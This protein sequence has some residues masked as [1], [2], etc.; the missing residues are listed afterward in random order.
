VRRVA[1]ALIRLLVPLVPRSSR[2]RWLEEWCAEIDHA[3]AALAGSRF[4]SLRVLRMALGAVSDVAAVRRSVRMRTAA[5]GSRIA[6]SRMFQGLAQDFRYSVRSLVGARGFSIGVITSLTLGIVANA[7]VFALI[8][9]L[10]FRPFPAIEAQDALVRIGFHRTCGRPGCVIHTSSYDDYNAMRDALPSLNGLTARSSA[11]VAVRIRGEASALG[12]ALV[13]ANYFTVLGVRPVLGRAFTAREAARSNAHVAVI[14]YRLWRRAF[15]G[16]HAVLGEFVDVGTESVQIVGVAPE[17]FAGVSKGDLLAIGDRRGTEIWLPLAIG[18][19]VA[20]RVPT[21]PGAPATPDDEYHI[22]YI[23][24]LAPGATLQQAAAEARVFA[25][26]LWAA[27]PDTR[28]GAYTNVDRV[29]ITNPS[30][31]IPVMAAF[32]PVPLL[33]LALA[34]LNAAN[35]FLARAT[36]RARDVAVRLALGASRWRIVRQL[37]MESVLLATG[38][39]ALAVPITAWILAL[40]QRFVPLPMPFDGGVL[41]LTL[42]VAGASVVMFGLAPAFRAASERATGALGSSRPGDVGART[43]RVRRGLVVAQIALSL[44]LLATGGQSISAVSAVIST[45][46]ASDPDRLILA[47]FDLN[48]LKFPAQAGREFYRALL[49]R[50]SQMPQIEAA[51]LARATVMWSFGRGSGNNRV[52]VWLPEDAPKKGRSFRGGY[53]A[54]DLFRA[55]GLRVIQGRGFTAEDAAARP[56]VAIVN[57]S[58]A[59]RL[60]GGAAIGRTV[61]VA[62]RNRYEESFDVRVVGIVEP[63]REQTTTGQ[64]PLDAIYLPAPLEY[65]PALTLYARSKV[66]MEVL[67]PALRQAVAEID[68]RVPLT[69]ASTLTDRTEFRNFEEHLMGRGATALGIV[70]LVLATAGLYSLFSFIVSLR[71]REMGV[72]MALGAEPSTVLRLVLRQA[73]RLAFVGAAIGG[74]IAI[75]AGALVHA[76]VY[77]TPSIDPFAFIASAALLLASMLTAGFV[78]AWRASRVDPMVVLRQE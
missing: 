17:G 44:G 35:L 29:W 14:S 39:A 62:A 71:A 65:E 58:M 42:A 78:P 45:T 49:D 5:A 41:G 76:E 23:G 34:C 46:G 1:R 60:F 32:M 56:H 24:R 37:L 20:G 4:G 8:N 12:A 69:E 18:D 70:A 51:G 61:R 16:D 68:G 26:R 47:S 55:I 73:M 2:D 31:I 9:S 67:V 52:A 15:H 53:I 10:F 66:P 43:T 30:T 64:Q 77:G 19:G 21:Q 54:G 75:I 25:A 57:P 63:T 27:R 11:H 40:T 72:R 48:Q 13:S 50:A 36:A 59:R 28:A 6:K 3:A 74:I 38:A 33:V 22:D 7:V